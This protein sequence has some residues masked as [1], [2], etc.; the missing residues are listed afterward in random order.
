M[1]FSLPFVALVLGLLLFAKHLT[2]LLA[3]ELCKNLLQRF[4]RSRCWGTSLLFA[5]A[6]WAFVL[7]ATTDLGE[8]SPLRHWILLFIVVAGGFFWW[9][10]PE[11][12]AVRS[13]GFLMLLL[14]HV[15]L[16]VSFLKSGFLPIMLSLLAYCWVIAGFFFVGMPYLLR[17][18]ITSMSNPKHQCLWKFL[19]WLGVL[20]GLI[21]AVSGIWLLF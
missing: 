1:S 17:N 8:F 20:Y 3:P 7:V 2:F 10:V 9:L 12:L 21:L 4:P 14:A 13:L 5:S 16:E 15:V 19:S 18:L 6:L 11:F